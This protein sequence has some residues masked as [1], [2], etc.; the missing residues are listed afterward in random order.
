MQLKYTT[1]PHQ[2]K[3]ITSIVDLFQGQN[4]QVCEYDIFDGEAVCGNGYILDDVAILENLQRVQR[5]NGIEESLM[6][7]SRDFSVEMETG[8]GKTYVYIKSILELYEKYGW[9]KYIIITPSIAIREGVLSSLA[10]MKAHFSSQY[11][12]PYDYFEYDSSRLGSLK[13]FIR[14][15]GLQV[16]VMT[17]DSFKRANT[18]LNMT[19][20]GFAGTPKESLQKTNPILILDEPQNME[21]ELSKTSIAEL[22]PLF[23]LRFSATHK[24]YYNLIY[25]LTPREALAQGLVKQIDVL[26]LSENQT[27][28]DTY[29]NVLKI[30]IDKKSKRPVATL[31]LII[32]NKDEFVTKSVKIKG[33]DS[34]KDKTKNPIYSGFIVNEINAREMFIQFENG[35][36]L[37]L[38]Q[39]NGQVK[40]QIQE[41]QITEAIAM[42]MEKYEVLKAKNIKVLS[43]FFIDRVANFLEEEDG[44]M[45]RHFCQEFDRLKVNYES[46]K[47]IEASDVY[48]YYFAKRKSGYIDD[49]KNNDSD[50]K[51]AKKTYDLIMKEKEKL[52][53]FEEKTSFIFSHSALKEGWD[54]PNVFFITT[55]NDTKSEMKK[56]QILGRGVR[57]AVDKFGNRVEDKE[58]NRLTVVA[59]E[60]FDE[61]AKSLQ[62]E[63]EAS[64]VSDGSIPN[65]IKKKKVATRK[66]AEV[67]LSN[68]F[69]ALWKKLKSKTIFELKL[70][71]ERYKEKVIRKLQEIETREQKIVRQFG[72]IEDDI[73]GYVAEE[74]SYG[75]NFEQTLPDLVSLIEQ[76]IGLT[77][78]M[79][80]EILGEVDLKPFIRNSD[81]YIKRALEAFD[82]AK[83]EV[84]TETADGIAY[85]ENGE[86][87]EFVNVFPDVL[88]GYDLE[89]C[90]R[91]LYDAEQWDSGI[92]K[93]FIG[94]A[95]THFKFFAKLPK[96]FKIKT[97]LGNYSPDFAVIKYDESEG[98]FVVE[99]KGSDK[100]RDMRSREA[101]QISYAKKHFK[102]LDVKY[103]DKIKSCNDV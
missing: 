89:D 6:L 14:D 47:E 8:T 28:N 37:E 80:I 98:A 34:L 103:K 70:D 12:F 92:E 40:R 45:Q 88:E 52:L 9:N 31:E 55:L 22:N 60:S 26:A 43:L 15:D 58:I 63:Y 91:G 68:E 21:S 44:W 100:H 39:I 102:F 49:L 72:T 71:E 10:S 65:N 83:H 86:Y 56:R 54:N 53:S 77:R 73:Y 67:E 50:R 1:Q 64:G 62:L 85:R 96:R 97:P 13:H 36:R 48:K 33:N 25:T 51:L 87:Y 32:K 82:D 42:H 41:Q 61:F 94:C 4:R 79:I 78:K 35:L 7:Q 59:N 18:I 93:D 24:N 5:E 2:T 69:R 11:R 84:L 81:S 90:K 74:K 95:D 66:Y 3:A 101:W 57:L 75:L 19:Q 46:F 99:T 38:S 20:E 76:E 23:T 29:V 17:I 16:M 30:E 27:V